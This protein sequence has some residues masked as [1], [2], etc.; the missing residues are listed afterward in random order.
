MRA[1]YR[2]VVVPNN[3]V[4][5]VVG[6]FDTTKVAAGIEKRTAEWKPRALPALNVVAPPAP[7]GSRTIISDP[8]A[9][10]LNV[11]VGHL[12]IKR[13]NPDYY[14]LLV[15]DNVLGSGHGFTDRLSATLRD[16]NGL[17]YSV[18]ASI[19]SGAGEEV[20]TFSGF[21]GTFPDKFADVTAGFFREV[22]RLRDEVPADTEVE[23]A[24]KYLTGSLAFSLTTCQQAADLLLAVDRYKL[25]AD[26]LKTYRA[27]VA[28]VTPAEVRAVAKKYLDPDKMT[29]VA[30]GAVDAEGR[31]LAAKKD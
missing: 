5:A 3:P 4:V 12:G 2:Q 30:A 19:A 25:G 9:A 24:K 21:I 29:V 15:M 14:K 7:K 1:F 13:D 6:D 18:H 16:R 22:R 23:D 8:D 26:Y 11:F 10:Q 28:A 27:A 20:G 17:A 31:P